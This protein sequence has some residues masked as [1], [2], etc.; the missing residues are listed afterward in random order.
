[1]LRQLRTWLRRAWRRRPL[2]QKLALALAAPVCALNLAVAFFGSS[3]VFP[4]SPFFL[5]E[6]VVALGK[7][8]RH[9]PFCLLSG[10]DP[11]EPL[12]A[13]TARKHGLPPGLLESVVTI[14]SKMRV[15]RISAAGAMGPGQL[16][17]GTAAQLGV[18]DPF[19]PTTALDGSARYLAAQVKRFKELPLAVAAYNAGPGAVD[20]HVPRNGETEH[21]V[22]NVMAE[23]QRRR[24]RPA[25]APTAGGARPAP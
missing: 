10:H 1:M 12:V 8:A 18:A 6:K 23:Y 11:L 19:D 25:A 21:Y 4:L 3:W 17:A 13:Q 9:R 2:W 20:D 14:E 15:H 22:A 24:P 7:Y 16:S 5:R